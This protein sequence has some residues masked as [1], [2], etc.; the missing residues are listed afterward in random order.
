MPGFYTIGGEPGSGKSFLTGTLAFNMRMAGTR[1]VIEDPSGP[2]A[3][4]CRMPQLAATSAELNL[5]RADDGTVSPP[6]MIPTPIRD[7]FRDGSGE[8]DELEYQR[9]VKMARAERTQ[10]SFDTLRGLLPLS[11]LRV[12]G[13]D[14]T[15]TRAIRAMAG[16]SRPGLDETMFNLRWAIDYLGKRTD[17]DL[18][19]ELWAELS[20]AAEFP[21]VSTA[22]P[23]HRDPVEDAGLPD[24]G[25]VVVTMPGIAAP[26]GDRDDWGAAERYAQPL[27]HLSAFFA[28][29]F[30]Y[31]R[32]RNERK[33][34]MFDEGDTLIQ[35]PSGRRL[36][37]RASSDSRKHNTAVFFAD[38]ES[39]TATAIGQ[40]MEALT[41][42]GFVGR[43]RNREAA[44]RACRMLGVSPMFAPV[45]QGLRTGEFVMV[46]PLRR[47]A[48]LMVDKDWHPALQALSTTPRG[49]RTAYTL[50]LPPAPVL[51]PRL[52]GEDSPADPVTVPVIHSNSERN[53][54]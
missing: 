5:A 7:H 31:S 13:V 34:L 22:I 29:R 48:K 16:Q 2:L 20:E 53:A 50:D 10:L 25:L 44:E 26:S 17:D 28:S 11:L 40:R 21:G 35:Q 18:A 30:I 51:D 43:L 27:I 15:L 38:Q 32:P 24:K 54:V 42:G 9:A 49:K 12:R 3:A 4:L 1:V 41:G 19:R 23:G 6:Q 45:I 52:F 39:S 37:R 14:Q 36:V 46:D 33:A 47:H 8:V